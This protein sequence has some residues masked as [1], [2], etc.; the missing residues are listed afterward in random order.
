MKDYRYGNTKKEANMKYTTKGDKNK[1]MQSVL[2]TIE[3]ETYLEDSCFIAK[4]RKH[5]PSG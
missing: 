1:H 2:K 3:L 4:L 5:F